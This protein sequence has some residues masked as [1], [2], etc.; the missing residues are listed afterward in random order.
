MARGTEQW[1][2]QHWCEL[3]DIG[4][5]WTSAWSWLRLES[6]HTG[7]DSEVGADGLATVD[8]WRGGDGGSD[9]GVGSVVLSGTGLE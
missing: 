5:G 9:H 6:S 8:A 7:K 1:E 3:I 2:R 4:H